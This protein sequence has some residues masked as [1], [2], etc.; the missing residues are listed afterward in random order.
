MKMSKKKNKRPPAVQISEDE[1]KLEDTYLFVTMPNGKTF[2]V[3]VWLITINHSMYQQE[4]VVGNDYDCETTI[5]LFADS[6]AAILDWAKDNMS[7]GDVREHATE[8]ISKSGDD[9]QLQLEYESGW[10]NGM[11]KISKIPNDLMQERN[12]VETLRVE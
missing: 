2:A 7:W 11:R 1:K 5:K 8:I 4:F 3:P 10:L 12:S 6:D 9:L